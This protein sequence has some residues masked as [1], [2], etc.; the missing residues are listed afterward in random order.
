MVIY[1]HLWLHGGYGIYK[2]VYDE[3][4]MCIEIHGMHEGIVVMNVVLVL[5]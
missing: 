3:Q 1:K 2:A 4:W 5:S